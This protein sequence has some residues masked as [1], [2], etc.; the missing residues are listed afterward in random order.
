MSDFLVLIGHLVGIAVLQ[1]VID[2]VFTNL[3]LEKQIPVV[4]IACVVISYA[5][6]LRFVY[7]HFLEEFT[8]LVNF[9]F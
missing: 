7:N 9:T 4:N 8:A 3:E 5:L 2:A 1:T 6:L